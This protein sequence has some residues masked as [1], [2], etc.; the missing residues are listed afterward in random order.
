M[1]L[2][3]SRAVVDAGYVPN[4]CQIGQS[5]YPKLFPTEIRDFAVGL[6]ATLS[7]LSSAIGTWFAPIS[8]EKFGIGETMF[9]AT[10]ITLRGLVVSMM[11]APETR[12]MSL[13]AGCSDP[14]AR[15]VA[16][17]L[18]RWLPLRHR[19]LMK[20]RSMRSSRPNVSVNVRPVLLVRGSQGHFFE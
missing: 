11:L 2:G 3:A 20:F 9:A 17:F 8:L 15:L 6:G 13:R 14:I 10:A 18:K 7:A 1:V 19:G 4:D 16:M 5:V 12:S